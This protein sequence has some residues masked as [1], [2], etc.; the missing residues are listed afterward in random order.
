[1]APTDRD[2]GSAGPLYANSTQSRLPFANTTRTSSP[3]ASL[4]RLST[5]LFPETSTEA[6]VATVFPGQEGFSG[7]GS[8][9]A[10]GPDP[11]ST[12]GGGTS[13]TPPPAPTTVVGS[14]LGSVAGV[15]LLVAVALFVLRWKRRQHHGI[16]LLEDAATRPRALSGGPDG[17]M[18][19]RGLP[20]AV[21]SALATLSSKRKSRAPSPGAGP[22]ERSFYRVSGRKLP[23]VLMHGGDGFTDPR[24]S[25]ASGQT[26]FR[27][28]QG[29]W[30]PATTP[31][32]AVGSPMRPESGIMI[33]QPGPGRTPVRTPVT[34]QR[35][36]FDDL[37]SQLTPPAGIDAIGRSRQSQ[38]GSRGSGSRFTEEI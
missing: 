19:D 7:A 23:P 1:M 2:A 3:S 14:V 20:F 24:D 34:E 25:V 29:F 11:V 30:E 28:S 32:F 21:P 37:D 35:P 8:T 17:T 4:F 16:R 12:H 6:A 18:A 22:A 13:G 27:D 9:V 5:S 26:T 15:A 36:F 10:A 38:D 31:R 33:M